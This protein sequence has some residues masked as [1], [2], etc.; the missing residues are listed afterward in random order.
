MLEHL[1]TDEFF[2][3]TQF[4]RQLP[5]LKNSFLK[6]KPYSFFEVDDLF[7]E[8]IL[9]KVI[10]EFPPKNDPI[11]DI[12]ANPKIEV[13]YRTNWKSEADIKPYTLALVQILNSGRFMRMVSEI[14]G[15]E[16]L[17]PDQYYTGGGLNQIFRGGELAVH[18]DGTG[19]DRIGL[20]RRI[21]VILFLNRDWQEDWG[22]QL[23]LWD[24]E[25]KSCQQ[26]IS[27]LFNKLFLFQTNDRTPHG[28]P[29][30]LLCPE[31]ISRK[32]LILYHYTA[33]RPED[34]K[35]FGEKHRALFTKMSD[36]RA[37]K[38]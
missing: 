14:T 2:A 20:Y 38:S 28:H 8:S 22:G 3:F 11:W 36:L 9:D 19:S 1:L 6:A 30:P 26:K 12:R 4:E 10:G 34:E 24:E 25:M 35:R 18:V 17:V 27:P 29:Y 21:N 13:K 5:T 16:G 15:I 37:A 23:E 32:S 33:S 7:S 31:G